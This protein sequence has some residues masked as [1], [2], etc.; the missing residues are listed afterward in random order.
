MTKEVQSKIEDYLKQNG[1]QVCMENNE[2]RKCY[3]TV[4]KNGYIYVETGGDV[5]EDGVY[6]AN[7]KIA[8][9]SY[10]ALFRQDGERLYPLTV[11]FP[12][13]HYNGQEK[14]LFLDEKNLL[15]PIRRNENEH[16]LDHY[17]IVDNQISYIFSLN[18]DKYGKPKEFLQ[19]KQLLIM[20]GNLYHCEQ[21]KF[22]PT[23]EGYPYAKVIDPK[24][25]TAL[26]EIAV[27]WKISEDILP[28]FVA[29]LSKRMQEDQLLG[30]YINVG[31]EKDNVHFFYDVLILLDKNG[32]IAHLW[33]IPN[34]YY[35]QVLK[36]PIGLE[37]NRV[38]ESIDVTTNEEM[39]KHLHALKHQASCLVK[40]TVMMRIE[41]KHEQ[42]QFQKRW[43]N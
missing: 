9:E 29:S 17:K 1:I 25:I 10:C 18:L 12:Y 43:G 27:S 6:V 8:A 39:I 19:D 35:S 42:Y 2:T 16:Y 5:Y 22:V 26:S 4:E 15:M 32:E 37:E 40:D 31:Y 36:N 30:G 13:Y 3:L 24:N 14:L 7:Q 21:G 28:D 41:Q 38:M 33:D 34:V 23:I 20:N 11:A